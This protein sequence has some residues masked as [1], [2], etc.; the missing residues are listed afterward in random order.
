MKERFAAAFATKTRDEWT[1]I[2]EGL[3]A[4]VTPVLSPLEAAA[5]PYNTEREVFVSQPE[6]QPAPAPRFSRTPGSIR[7][8]LSVNDALGGWG[9]SAERVEELRRTGALGD[10]NAA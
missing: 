2:F 8:A 5:H 9:V 1:S 10:G 3:D 4:C 6:L 7:P